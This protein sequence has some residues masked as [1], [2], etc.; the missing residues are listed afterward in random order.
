MERI[1]HLL[2]VVQRSLFPAL[3]E[4][5]G[6]LSCKDQ[7]FV[8]ALEVL[9]VERHI[10]RRGWLGRRPK[11]RKALARAFV[12]KAFYN[13]ATTGALLERLR[14]DKVVRR[15]CGW[16]RKNQVPSES[17]FSRAFEEFARSGLADRVHEWC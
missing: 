6:D 7:Q 12:A 2:T 10:P 3:R 9:G 15:I 8:R 4:E 16:E 13:I 14:V 1:S 11:D 5:V 17:T